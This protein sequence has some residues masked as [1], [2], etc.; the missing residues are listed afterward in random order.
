M[1]CPPREDTWAS[2]PSI[3]NTSFFSELKYWER[4]CI[5]TIDNLIS[6]GMVIMN[7]RYLCKEI[8]SSIVS[9]FLLALVFGL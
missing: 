5:L 7:G 4:G 1:P 2:I 3:D 8:V 6:R 9:F